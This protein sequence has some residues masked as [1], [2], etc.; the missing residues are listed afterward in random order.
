MICKFA[1][2]LASWVD[3]IGVRI[4]MGWVLQP[5][6]VFIS[7]VN[8][9]RYSAGADNGSQKANCW[10]MLKYNAIMLLACVRVN[11]HLWSC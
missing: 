6:G 3:G 10:E 7:P 2:Q 5:T 8:R 9:W 4:C 1:G 11:L